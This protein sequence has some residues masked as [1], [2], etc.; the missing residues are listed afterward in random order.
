MQ[1]FSLV[2]N[3]LFVFLEPVDEPRPTYAGKQ[4]AF[5]GMAVSLPL[6][7]P[8]WQSGNTLASHLWGRGSIPVTA[9]SGKAGSCLP[10]VGSLQYTTLVNS[11]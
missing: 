6:K 3:N 7:G 1:L 10:L 11:M 4:Y 2:Y 9:L 8:R 5:I